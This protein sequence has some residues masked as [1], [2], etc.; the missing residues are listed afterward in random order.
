[1][2][3][4]YGF[5]YVVAQLS[6][7]LVARLAPA[8]II[9]ADAGVA[10]GRDHLRE[11]FAPPRV[12]VVPK[13]GP[14]GGRDAAFPGNVPAATLQRPRMSRRAT[15]EVHCWGTDYDQ[16]EILMDQ[17]CNAAMDV[18][19]GQ[20]EFSGASWAEETKIAQ[21]GQRVMFGFSCII[22]IV[23]GAVPSQVVTGVQDEGH[24]ITQNGGDTIAC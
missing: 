23:D 4:S 20:L 18:A 24:F 13:G 14:F 3:G 12:I 2:S 22:P 16:A 9:L 19:V 15:G 5:A 11:Q 6:T 21:A 7:V 10:F 8:S 17:F 1:M